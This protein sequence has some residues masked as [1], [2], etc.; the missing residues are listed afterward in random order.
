MKIL[1]LSPTG[2][3]RVTMW[4]AK[5]KPDGCLLYYKDSPVCYAVA[6]IEYDDRVLEVGVFEMSTALYNYIVS[7]LQGRPLTGIHIMFVSDHHQ[8][9][10]L[11]ETGGMHTLPE[12]IQAEMTALRDKVGI[13]TFHDDM[14]AALQQP[15]RI[16]P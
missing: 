6:A 13:G 2:Y 4:A 11:A 10:L 14:R 1:R 5:N 15:P 16:R 3:D 9:Y 8:T 12:D 7:E